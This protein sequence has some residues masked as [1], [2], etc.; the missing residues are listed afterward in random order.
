MFNHLDYW[1]K[2]KEDFQQEDNPN[3]KVLDSIIDFESETLIKKREELIQ[4]IVGELK[5]SYA[6]PENKN[7]QSNLLEKIAYDFGIKDVIK[8]GIFQEGSC[9]EPILSGVGKKDISYGRETQHPLLNEIRAAHAAPHRFVTTLFVNL[10]L[11]A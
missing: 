3:L 1:S 5:A 7:P 9:Q 8:S 10:K 4:N 6:L 2:I 11:M